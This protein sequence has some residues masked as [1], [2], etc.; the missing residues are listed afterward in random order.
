MLFT[1][2]GDPCITLSIA[3]IRIYF[4]APS[5]RALKRY[6]QRNKKKQKYTELV[7]VLSI[8]QSSALGK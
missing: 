4:E 3:V 1:P 8:F 2:F 7:I 5:D 6:L